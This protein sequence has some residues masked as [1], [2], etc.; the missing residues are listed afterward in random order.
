MLRF[1]ASARRRLAA[2][3]ALSC[4]VAMPF[5]VVAPDVHDVDTE[6][7][8]VVRT[9]DQGHSPAKSGGSQDE[10]VP[11]PSHPGHVDHCTHAHLLVLGVTEAAS[12]ASLVR[13]RVP[14]ARSALPR[15]VSLSPHQR[16][17]IA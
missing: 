14:D 2:L 12:Q 4:V 5:E 10:R 16:P 6:A 8:P 11:L 7:T 3:F 17:P 1:H 13:S 9:S 15:S